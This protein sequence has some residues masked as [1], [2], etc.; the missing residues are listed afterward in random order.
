MFAG[1]EA[2]LDIHGEQQEGSEDIKCTKCGRYQKDDEYQD[3]YDLF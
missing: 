3:I 2:N 1:C